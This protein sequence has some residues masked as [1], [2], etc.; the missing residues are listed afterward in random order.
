[1]SEISDVSM[2]KYFHSL[3]LRYPEGVRD[4]EGSKSNVQLPVRVGARV[5]SAP[6]HTRARMRT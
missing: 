3:D 2:L 5:D 4:Q 1:M 6:T